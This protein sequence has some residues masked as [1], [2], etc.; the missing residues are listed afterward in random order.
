MRA[1]APGHHSLYYTPAF[2]F[3][4]SLALAAVSAMEVLEVAF[5][6]ESVAV[7]GLGIS[8]LSDREAQDFFHRFEDC[9]DFAG[10]DFAG[11]R[12]GMDPGLPEYLVRI[13]VA[14][15]GKALLI[16]QGG[17]DGVGVSAFDGAD[18]CP[19]AYFKSVGSQFPHS[20]MEIG[21]VS[22]AK[23]HR[24]ELADIR[25]DQLFCLL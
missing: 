4:A 1:T 11:T 14:D 17:F 24:S 21:L 19:L 13:D 8:A 3:W 10:R 15:A 2:L 5:V 20:F 6:A 23:V 22:L 12:E 25:E 18:E 16:H 7:I 9:P